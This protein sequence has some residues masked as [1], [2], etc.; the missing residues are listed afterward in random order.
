MESEIVRAACEFPQ[1]IHPVSEM[2]LASYLAG[3]LTTAQFL[4][5]FSLPNSD[6]IELSAC[7]VQVMS[8]F[9]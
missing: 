3:D 6:Y 1:R 8:I 9:S 4:R 2:I 5:F 7:F